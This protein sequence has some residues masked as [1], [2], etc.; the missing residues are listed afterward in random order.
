MDEWDKTMKLTTGELASMSWSPER[1]YRAMVIYPL[2][3][4]SG[5]RGRASVEL[6][7]N[8]DVS[9]TTDPQLERL[10]RVLDYLSLKSIPA[11]QI[12]ADSGKKIVVRTA[13]GS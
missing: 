10:G 8:I 4:D 9:E 11:R 12:W 2:K 6:G 13:R 1:G 3:S 5:G 7:Q